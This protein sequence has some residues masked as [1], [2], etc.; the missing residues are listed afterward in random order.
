MKVRFK[1]LVALLISLSFSSCDKGN[2]PIFEMPLFFDINIPAGLNTF[3]SHFFIIEDVPTFSSTLLSA[4]GESTDNIG[5]ILAGAGF[6]E[7]RF[8]G[9]DLDF[10]EDI[11]VHVL[12]PNDFNQ[13]HEAYYTLNDVVPFGSKTK[14]DMIPS[15]VDQ[16]EWLLNETVDLEFRINLRGFLPQEIDGRVEMRF[17][18]YAPE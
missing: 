17:L 13:R 6:L 4:N 9:L 5:S 12:E 15:I 7:T 16:K 8:S 2:D 10:I 3:Q 18:A 14:I 11:G 1:L